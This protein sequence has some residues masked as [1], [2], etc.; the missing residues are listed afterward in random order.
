MT[1]TTA[2]FALVIAALSFC[3][4]L[5][6]VWRVHIKETPHAWAEVEKT[7]TPRLYLLTIKLRN[8]TQYVLKFAAL[9]IPLERIP[10]DERQ[11]FLM[12]KID[13]FRDQT[14]DWVKDNLD[15]V[16]RGSKL[17][18]AGEILPG[19]TGSVQMLLIRGSLSAALAAKV[20]VY[21]W[22]MG[23]TAQYKNQV[24]TATVPTSGLTFK[25]ASV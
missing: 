13:A 7:T 22:S 11:S 23:N 8:P 14:E 9:S 6:S 3:L 5:Y 4:S 15:K 19:E 12:I 20:T 18:V 24:V 10:I 21:Y 1:Q 16:E 2:V 25:I 17:D